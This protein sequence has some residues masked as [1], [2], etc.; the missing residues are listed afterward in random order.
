MYYSFIINE[1]QKEKLNK[2]ISPVMDS[3]LEELSIINS[4]LNN[5]EIQ[6]IFK[7]IRG[8]L[9]W[10]YR[11]SYHKFKK[12]FIHDIILNEECEIKV[13]NLNYD[14]NQSVNHTIREII[15]ELIYFN[16]NN[17]ISDREEY[18][19]FID[20]INQHINYFIED[21]YEYHVQEFIEE[22]KSLN[23]EIQLDE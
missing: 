5:N 6:V 14:I 18:F 10:I 3:T 2:G 4:L 12:E 13:Y 19:E 15:Y 22:L 1:E 16:K 23:I 17:G 9:L 11:N 20:T 8:Y 21:L 7:E